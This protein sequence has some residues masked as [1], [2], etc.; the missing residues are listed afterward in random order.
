MALSAHVP[1]NAVLQSRYAAVG[2]VSLF[3]WVDAA[4]AYYHLANRY[5]VSK[6][7][8]VPAGGT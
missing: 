7:T 1:A 3:R 8:S 2:R 4:S 6:L 5:N